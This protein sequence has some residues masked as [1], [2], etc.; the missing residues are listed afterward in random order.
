MRNPVRA[1]ALLTIGLVAL[2]LSAGCDVPH[3]YQKAESWAP[4]PPGDP[5]AAPADRPPLQVVVRFAGGAVRL[6]TVT[7]DELYRASIDH[8]VLHT[9]PSM[10]LDPGDENA[11]GRLEV[12]LTGRPGVL[13]GFGGEHN[14]LDLGLS[15]RVPQI[16]DVSLGE[17]ESIINLTGLLVR[18]LAVSGGSGDVRV[19]FDR[20]NQAKADELSVTGMVGDIFLGRLGNANASRVEVKGGIGNVELDL[21][22]EWRRDVV[23]D[24]DG[25]VGNILMTV[26]LG[27]AVRLRVGR[28]WSEKLEIPGFT[29][30]GDDFMSPE[31]GTVSPRIDVSV[32][33]GIGA[34]TIEEVDEDGRLK[35]TAHGSPRLQ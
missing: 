13:I 27:R 22:G 14:R 32:E 34:L 28:P 31:Y 5:M 35:A 21:S 12:G 23:L 15:P 4:V 9:I 17:G 24:V 30:E 29:R 2:A 20:P 7:G 33:A 25:A 11:V 3:E 8:C 1:P 26:P 10:K 6:G 16:L 19:L 18:G